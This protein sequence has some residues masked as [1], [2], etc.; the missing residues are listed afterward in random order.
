MKPEQV[1]I[2]VVV[3]VVMIRSQQSEAVH[4][5]PV[6]P[7]FLA[8]D[9]MLVPDGQVKP[10]QVGIGVVVT[11]V[12]IRL[13]QSEAVHLPPVHPMFLASGL[14]LVPDGQEKPAQ[15]GRGVV[16]KVGAGVVVAVVV[17]A[18]Q[19]IFAVQPLTQTRRPG[20][21]RS[22][23]GDG[24]VKPEQVGTGV[25]VTVVM[26][27][28]QQS[29]AVHVPPVHPMLLASAL[30]LVPDGHVKPAQVGSGVVVNVGAGVVVTVVGT[31][32]LGAGVV[33]SHGLGP[34]TKQHVS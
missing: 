10:A 22:S 9:L 20:C 18:K 32:V 14:M 27:R 24:Q 21:G 29:E 5:P 28:S 34:G 3:T 11:V 25:V 17:G 12:M 2:G 4:L 1:G 7:M 16:V 19:Q 23:M 13:Q 33:V 15:V 30:M 6:H 8:S 31:G 26:I